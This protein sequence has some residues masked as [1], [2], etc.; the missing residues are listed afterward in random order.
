MN[1]ITSDRVRIGEYASSSAAVLSHSSLTAWD[2]A[3][4]AASRIL[5]FRWLKM[6]DV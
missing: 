6:P 4:D 5:G 3:L 2:M 1:A